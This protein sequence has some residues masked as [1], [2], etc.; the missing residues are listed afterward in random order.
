[1]VS[2]WSVL[3]WVPAE[4]TWCNPFVDRGHLVV[5]RRKLQSNWVTVDCGKAFL[6][7]SNGGSISLALLG[8]RVTTKDANVA[9]KGAIR[10]DYVEGS[11]LTECLYRFLL[12]SRK[13]YIFLRSSMRFQISSAIW[14]TSGQRETLSWNHDSPMLGSWSWVIYFR[15]THIKRGRTLQCHPPLTFKEL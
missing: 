9:Q 13:W 5:I 7:F 12:L 15:E 4:V 10:Y 3:L 11:K 1:M 2:R 8:H 6:L 14:K